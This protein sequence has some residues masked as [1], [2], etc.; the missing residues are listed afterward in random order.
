MLKNIFYPTIQ[1]AF[2]WISAIYL[3]ILLIIGKADAMIILFAY[4]LEAIIIG[5]FNVLKLF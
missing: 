1:N 5:V 2:V 4:F 3:S